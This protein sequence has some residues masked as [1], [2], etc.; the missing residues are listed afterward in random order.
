MTQLYLKEKQIFDESWFLQSYTYLSNGAKA[1]N[2][3]VRDFFEDVYVFHRP[4]SE[5]NNK[6]VVVTDDDSGSQSK[7][8]SRVMSIYRT[9]S[10]STRTDE[11]IG[12]ELTSFVR[13]FKYFCLLR[14][15]ITMMTLYIIDGLLCKLLCLEWEYYF[16]LVSLPK[17]M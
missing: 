11:N 7:N 2:S 1:L 13:P 3:R 17:S 16:S 6:M 12:L 10:K 8:Q 4:G 5:E 9:S 14:Y 15:N